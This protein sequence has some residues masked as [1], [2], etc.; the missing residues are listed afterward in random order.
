MTL[1]DRAAEELRKVA[2]ELGELDSAGRL[3]K[4]DQKRLRKIRIKLGGTAMALGCETFG[5]D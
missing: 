3:S 4:D 2:K 1:R 5:E